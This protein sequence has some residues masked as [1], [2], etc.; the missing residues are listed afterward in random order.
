MT[1][2]RCHSNAYLAVM[3]SLFY[4]YVYWLSY[5]VSFSCFSCLFISITFGS[6]GRTSNVQKIYRVAQKS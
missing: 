6:C 2:F 5:F 3:L 1:T 4:V